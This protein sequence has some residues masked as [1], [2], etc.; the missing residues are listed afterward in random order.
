LSRRNIV[1]GR[2]LTTRHFARNAP[3]R[4]LGRCRAQDWPDQ[5]IAA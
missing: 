2:G 4:Q 5:G 3:N 1:M